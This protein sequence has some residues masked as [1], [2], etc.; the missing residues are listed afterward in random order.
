MHCW[1]LGPRDIQ[2]D[3]YIDD[4]TVEILDLIRNRYTKVH[5]ALEMRLVHHKI[6][7]LLNQNDVG[8]N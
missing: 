4:R 7:I 1:P 6:D 5:Q 3:T 2:L 8:S